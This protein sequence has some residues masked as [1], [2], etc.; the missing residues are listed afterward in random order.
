MEA[1]CLEDKVWILIRLS[2]VNLH[3][4]SLIDEHTG[5]IFEAMAGEFPRV[6]FFKVDVDKAKEVAAKCGIQAMPAFQVFKGGEMAEE[7]QGA[8]Q[9]GL[10]NLVTK[11]Q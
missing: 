3:S 11:H 8:D 2:T 7:M 9:A 5:P 1:M 6:A 10:K 4:L